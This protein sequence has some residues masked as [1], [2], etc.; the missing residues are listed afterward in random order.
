MGKPG[1][2]MQISQDTIRGTPPFLAG[3]RGTAPSRSRLGMGP[4]EGRRPWERR[5][6]NTLANQRRLTFLWILIEAPALNR[7][8][9]KHR[10]N[11]IG[12]V[13]IGH[14]TNARAAIMPGRARI[15]QARPLPSPSPVFS[16]RFRRRRTVCKVASRVGIRELL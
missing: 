9:N 8:G 5:W 6:S 12:T 7:C 16:R 2:L 4:L 3:T 10:N 11:R 1:D 14:D 15:R 13:E